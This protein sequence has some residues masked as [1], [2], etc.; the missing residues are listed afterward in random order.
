M[1]EL[2]PNARL[3]AGVLYCY[4]TG[5]SISHAKNKFAGKLSMIKFGS[6]FIL[7]INV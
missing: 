1:F 3:K 6:S 5:S 2:C 4:Y 7:M